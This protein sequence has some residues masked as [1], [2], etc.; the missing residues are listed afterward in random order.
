MEFFEYGTLFD[1][2]DRS[3]RGEAVSEFTTTVKAIVVVGVCYG[4]CF[5]HSLDIVHQNLSPKKIFLDSSYL[6][7]IGG[8]SSSKF[9]DCENTMTVDGV[10]D[11][12][13]YVAAEASSVD[14]DSKVDV[15]SFG[16]ILLEFS[17]NRW[18]NQREE[19]IIEGTSSLTAEIIEGC[20]ESDPKKR[21]SFDEIIQKIKNRRFD[22]F[23]GANTIEIT[24]YATAINHGYR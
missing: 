5:L 6:P 10:F 15:Y 18:L 2:M 20:L 16:L 19:P 8:F 4:M 21:F 24:E 12:T 23:E 13:A 17:S 7:K 11:S 22:L 9:F 14:Y 3:I 1:L